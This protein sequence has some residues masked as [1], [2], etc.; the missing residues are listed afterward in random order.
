M[1]VVVYFNKDENFWTMNPQCTAAGVFKQVYE[2]DKTK[3]KKFSSTLMWCIALIFDYKSTF[4]NL[5]ETGEDNKIDLIFDDVLGDVEWPTKNRALFEELRDFY[6]A[7]N[8]TQ[9]QRA[10]RGV[11]EKLLE[12]DQFLKS[13]TYTMGM[14]G[15]RG[16]WIGNTADILDKMTANTK[17]LWDLYEQARKQVLQETE[18]AS[19]IGGRKE[20]LTDQGWG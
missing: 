9:A 12:R 4:Y 19:K 5:P 7:L 17:K 20:S 18:G 1:S 11:E 3:G 2:D 6:R 13:V 10:L 14:P 16:G 8:E 15:E